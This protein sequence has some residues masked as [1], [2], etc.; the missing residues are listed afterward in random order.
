MD[1]A[2]NR[3][4]AWVSIQTPFTEQQ[5]WVF[6]DDLERMFRINSLLVID[7]WAQDPSGRILMKALNLSNGKTVNTELRVEKLDDGLRINYA[8][9]LKSFTRFQ[10]K[11]SAN[12]TSLLTITDD[13]T[14]VPEAE[15]RQRLEEVDQSLVQWGQ[16]LHAYMRAWRRWSWF[17]PW[18]IYMARIWQPMK[19]VARRITRWLL[20]ITVA[21]FVAFLLVFAVFVIEH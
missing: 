11:P 7:L 21:E 19:P 2:S 5:L 3:D 1:E 8:G 17:P 9:L 20:W 16:D 4:S 12:G 6:I 14:A 10:I 15:R 18:R 13:Y